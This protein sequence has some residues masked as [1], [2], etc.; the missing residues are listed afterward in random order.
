MDISL[1]E[2]FTRGFLSET[3]DVLTNEEINYLAFS[4]KYIVYEQTIRFFGDY[5]NGDQYYKTKYH[6]HNLVRTKAQFKLLQ[7]MEEQFEEM[8]KIVSDLSSE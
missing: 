5:L 8:E 1:F 6:Q 3:K 4:A 2:G 7:S